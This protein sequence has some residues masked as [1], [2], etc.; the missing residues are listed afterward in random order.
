MG[1]YTGE[2]SSWSKS[3]RLKKENGIFQM[4]VELLKGKTITEDVSPLEKVNI[5]SHKLAML[6]V[7]SAEVS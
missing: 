3:V 7:L 1:N 6:S 2:F 4:T 5:S